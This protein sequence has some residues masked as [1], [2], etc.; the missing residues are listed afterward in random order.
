MSTASHSRRHAVLGTRT[1]AAMCVV[2]VVTL[3]AVDTGVGVGA[4][5]HQP[6]FTTRVDNVRVDVEVRRGGRLAAGL[7]AADFEV[8]DNGVLQ[9][10]EIV[11]PSTVPVSVI[12]ALD[13][14]ASLD[15]RERSHLANASL[16][17]IDALKPGESATLLT[18]TGRIAIQSMFTS[19]A[20][21][22]GRSL[23]RRCRRET[24]HS[25]M[26]LMSQCSWSHRRQGARS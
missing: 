8:L 15:A 5:A 3:A 7:T 13:S 10:V 9:K 23:P 1:R 11:D 4:D 26:R 25:T 17:V 2:V 20:A 24:Q 6:S 21:N 14:S 22:C 12:L 16:R 19:D 18:F